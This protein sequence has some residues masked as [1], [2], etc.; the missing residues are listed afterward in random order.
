MYFFTLCNFLCVVF[1]LCVFFH[2]FLG[3]ALPQGGWMRSDPVCARNSRLIQGTA[4][5]LAG[6]T[7]PIPKIPAGMIWN[8]LQSGLSHSQCPSDDL[9]P[10]A[11]SWD[12]FVPCCSCAV[13][14]AG[15]G[16]P[17]PWNCS[18]PCLE[19]GFIPSSA[20]GISMVTEQHLS[21][22]PAGNSSPG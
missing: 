18:G 16:V 13:S 15:V 9:G 20:G 6:G 12:L 22:Y 17:C 10:F 3:L 1:S 8:T 4:A 2:L 19:L 5:G 11:G 21:F 14:W 7:L